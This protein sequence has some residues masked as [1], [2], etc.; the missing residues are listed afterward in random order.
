[1]VCSTRGGHTRPGRRNWE[2]A[3]VYVALWKLLPGPLWLRILMATLIALDVVA[4]LF[5]V[6]FP[7]VDSA[8]SAGQVTVVP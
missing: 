3:S 4:L 8:L 1:M 2:G 7:L 5:F 6:V